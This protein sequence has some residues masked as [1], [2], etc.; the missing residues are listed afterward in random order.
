MLVMHAIDDLPAFPD[1]AGRNMDI[2]E[3]II[4]LRAFVYHYLTDA[5]CTDDQNVPFHFATHPP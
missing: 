1:I 2:P 3:D 4:M 5:T